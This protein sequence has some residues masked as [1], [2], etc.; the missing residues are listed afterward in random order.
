MQNV[1]LIDRALIPREPLVPLRVVLVGLA[2]M[3]L[4]VGVHALLEQH[5]ATRALA[6]DVPAAEDTSAAGEGV[7]DA[8]SM[9][10]VAT[11]GALLAAL[12]RESGLANPAETF[13]AI[14]G[15]LPATMW[16]TEVELSGA[17]GL[18]IAGGSLD[19]QAV[20]EF[21]RRLAG[22]LPGTAVATLRLEAQTTAPTDES[23]PAAA[24]P[25][26]APVVHHFVLAT[27]QAQADGRMA[28]EVPR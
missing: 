1:N 18:R 22:P 19:A 26:P 28:E 15:A 17:R 6:L 21:A 14:V 8:A 27:P 12:E 5:W 25:A 23:A 7:A 2:C 4:A 3:A 20:G 10:L 11:R 13:R 24:A 9:R 16:L